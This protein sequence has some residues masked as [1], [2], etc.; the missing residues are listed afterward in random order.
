MSDALITYAGI[1]HHHSITHQ[2]QIGCDKDNGCTGEDEAVGT[3]FR[4]RGN[5][6]KVSVHGMPTIF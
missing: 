1:V 3:G 6:R 5:R 2:P 4:Q